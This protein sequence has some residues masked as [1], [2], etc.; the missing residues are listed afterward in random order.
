MPENT[1]DREKLLKAMRDFKEGRL[2]FLDEEKFEDKELCTAF[3]EM[4]K[5]VM[6]ANTHYLMRIN[7]SMGLIGDS[8][9]LKDMFETID[10][11]SENLNL[12]KA[13][14]DEYARTA[15]ETDEKSVNSLAGIRLI[16]NNLEPCITNVDEMLAELDRLLDPDEI[17]T[18]FVKNFRRLL[19]FNRRSLS[20]MLDQTMDTTDSI[21]GMHRMVEEQNVNLKPLLECVDGLGDSCETLSLQCFKAGQHMYEISRGIDNARNDI[22]RKDSLPTLHDC[23]KIYAVDHLVL[24]WRLYNHM[25]EYE[26]LKLAQ[27]NNPES[28]KFGVWCNMTSPKWIRETPEFEA[29]VTAHETLHSYAVACYKAKEATD[30]KTAKE[31]FEKALLA[32]KEFV[33]S[34]EALSR[35]L[36]EH[37]VEDSTDIQKISGR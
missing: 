33:D 17:T 28:C 15:G 35:V 19:E 30:M 1:G 11:Q 36:T 31:E 25:A 23:L 13:I 18:D 29:A 27:V 9:W 7:N 22:F 5:G 3:N 2:N 21:N 10:V 14:R 20:S 4:A 32:S 8:S 16:E 12:L 26:T 24:T 6:G 37:G 34:L